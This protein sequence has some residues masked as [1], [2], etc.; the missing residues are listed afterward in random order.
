MEIT[1]EVK[2]A[3]ISPK[4]VQPWLA[5]FRRKRAMEAL[6]SL[7]YARSK[8]GKMLYKLI[9]SAVAN[10]INNYN[11]KADNLEIK[12]LVVGEGPRQ[13]RYWLRSHGAADV[14]LK[15]MAHLKVVLQEITPV[16]VEKK[17]PPVS[18][19]TAPKTAPAKPAGG[20]VASTIPTAKADLAKL[21]GRW[22]GKKLF[23]RT[24][25]K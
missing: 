10:A 24:T 11:F 2:F 6:S 12:S 20:S 3:R 18:P 14:R 8:T 16:K 9:A 25:N 4:K 5:G 22:G 7:R 17:S 1:A 21:R 15:R 23:P 13:K 19:T